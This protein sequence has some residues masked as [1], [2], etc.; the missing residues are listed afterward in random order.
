[1]RNQREA[2]HVGESSQITCLDLLYAPFG[3]SQSIRHLSL[4]AIIFN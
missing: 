2:H 3:G 4:N 1:M